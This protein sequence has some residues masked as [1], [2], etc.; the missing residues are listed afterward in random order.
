MAKTETIEIQ[1]EFSRQGGKL[2]KYQDLVLGEK[3]L[4]RL[5][6]YECI[7]G[8]AGR[9]PGAFGLLLRSR[10]Y[11]K[12]LGRAGRNVTF[13]A[14]VVLR[15]PRKITIGD[16]VVVDDGCVL[17]AKG[18]DNRG[19]VLGNGV[20]LGRNTIL[21][22]KNG[23]ITLED[24]VNVGS[25]VT[26]FSAS[27]VRVGADNLI[28]A[29]CY[30]VGGTHN[31][32]DPGVPVLHQGRTSSGIRVGPGGWLGAHVTVFDGVRIGRH[33]VIGAGSVV[34]RDVP[35]YAVAA[36]VPAKVLKKRKPASARPG[37]TTHSKD[38]SAQMTHSKDASTQSMHSEDATTRLSHSRKIL[39]LSMYDPR[40]PYTGA[41]ARGAQFVNFLTKHYDLDLVYM[42]GSGHPGK[43][44][45]E[46]KFKDRVQ[47]ADRVIAIPFTQRGYFLFSKPLYGA[48]A[49]LCRANRYD[50]IFCDYGLAGRYGLKLNRRFGVP[51]IYSSHNVEFRQYLGKAKADPRRWPLVPYVRAFEKKAVKACALLVA[52]SEEDGAFFT[53]WKSPDK[54]VVVPQ[55]FDES[56]FNP[57]Y[58]PPKNDP[59]IV[60]F[61]GNYRISTNRDAVRTIRERIAGP[62]IERMPNVVFRF[63]G[64][65]PPVEYDHPNFEFTGFVDSVADEIKKADA[66][67]SPVQGGWGMPTKVVESLACGKP[68][69]ATECGAR[70]VP[71][72]FRGLT[73]CPIDG[74][75][76]AV[77]RTLAE[78]RPV[79]GRDFEPLKREF[80]WT[81][82]L[83]RLRK[84]I[85][86]IPGGTPH[87]KP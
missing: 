30:L 10:L 19:I 12:L 13:G 9:M 54:I 71:R 17:D 73:V 48:A 31:F 4:F 78:N 3:S 63:V 32:S 22:C 44:E 2:A 29:Y 40:V 80:L 56:V 5:L 25:N 77:V 35:D 68:V 36:G 64:A 52:I 21:N 7:T 67:I 69:I 23:D 66:V 86:E 39:Y 49:R 70:S 26:V 33:A 62:V 28:A 41:G 38:A 57:F 1:K 74:F 85:D 45:L 60:L 82:R 50:F 79:D 47:G 14:G 27:D 11:P 83:E 65:N 6:R 18:S 76:D 53:R 37:R 16:N 42:T 15:H 55:G 43:P 84:I 34:N 58:K 24:N 8:M 20:F 51:F 87:E 61:F 81:V 46:E 75:A 59:K 72:Q